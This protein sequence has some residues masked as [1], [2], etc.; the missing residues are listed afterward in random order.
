MAQTS[1]EAVAECREKAIE[2]F[3]DFLCMLLPKSRPADLK[4]GVVKIIDKTLALKHAMAEEQGVYR[5]FMI[6]S[7]NPKYSI[8]EVDV[9]EDTVGGT[10]LM[11]TSPGLRR[12]IVNDEMRMEMSV[13]VK[14]T[15]E[16]DT[17]KGGK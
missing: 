5:C 11:C 9:G 8:L 1:K 14:A 16:L 13:V 7:G 2:Y 3:S 4:E 12:Y 10:L 15:G 17:E 6:R